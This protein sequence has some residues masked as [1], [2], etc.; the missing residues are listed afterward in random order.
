MIVVLQWISIVL[1]LLAT[2][3]NILAMIRLNRTRKEA[4]KRES[5]Y[6]AAYKEVARMRDRYHEMLNRLANA[7]ETNPTGQGGSK[8]D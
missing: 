4:A 6:R 8:N 1:C 7:K 5:L 3:M 2:G